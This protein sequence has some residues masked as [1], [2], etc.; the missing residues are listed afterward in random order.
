MTMRSPQI[1][2]VTAG[3]GPR[4]TTKYG[5]AGGG[6]APAGGGGRA[7]RAPA[8]EGAGG[9]RQPADQPADGEEHQPRGERARELVEQRLERRLPAVV[10]Q[11][12]QMAVGEEQQ[13][14]QDDPTQP[15]GQE[16]EGGLGVGGC[17]LLHRALCGVMPSEASPSVPLHFVEREGPEIKIFQIGKIAQ[18]RSPSP[19]SGEGAGGEASKGRPL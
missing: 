8:R 4:G 3:G 1:S 12:L 17:H 2:V 16:A 14:Q 10:R 5:A 18:P 15:E 13:A 11:H 7:G 19:R 6:P 9:E